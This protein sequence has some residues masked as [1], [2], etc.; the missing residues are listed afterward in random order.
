MPDTLI[1]ADRDL[2]QAQATLLAIRN[3]GFDYPIY[4]VR[5]SAALV[6]RLSAPTAKSPRPSAIL[7]DIALLRECG[8]ELLHCLRTP[9][10]SP[11]EV[12]ALLSSEREQFQLEQC[13]VGK[14]GYLV[15]PVRSLDALRL[16]GVRAKSRTPPAGHPRLLWPARP[17]H[18]NRPQAVPQPPR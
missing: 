6:S 11:V 8:P 4:Y 16:L 1:I 15:R 12:T 3:A 9:D 2:D 13:G 7:I 5:S 14:I 17:Q 18:I 10:A